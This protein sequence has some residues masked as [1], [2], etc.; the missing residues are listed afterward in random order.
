MPRIVCSDAARQSAAALKLMND[1]VP[2]HLDWS[3]LGAFEVLKAPLWVLDVERGRVLWANA[4]ALGLWRASSLADMQSTFEADRSEAAQARLNAT[5]EMVRAGQTLD[6]FW[7]VYP[8]GNPITFEA[9]FSGVILADRRLSVLVQGRPAGEREFPGELKRRVESYRHAPSPISLHRP[10]GTAFMRNPAAIRVF[11]PLDEDAARDDLAFQLGGAEV[12]AQA[13]ATLEHQPVQRQRVKVESRIGLRW[14]DVELRNVPDP[15]TGHESTLFSAQDVTE[16]QLAG[17]RLAAEKH[18]LEMI[19]T[20]K[21]LTEVLDALTREVE[22][23]SPDMKCSVL[24]LDEDGVHM[25]QASAPSLPEAYCKAIDGL[26]IG[27]RV[28]SC[29]TAMFR[30]QTVIV[31]DIADDPLWEDYRAIAA[32]HDLRACWSVP[33]LSSSGQVLG[34]FAAYYRLP[35]TPSGQEM[36]LLETG[37]HIAGV[38]VERDRA[39][40]ALRT[41]SEQLQM[42]MDAMP[43]SIAFADRNF[44]YAVVNRR[45]EE[46]FGRH[47]E[48]V[49]GKQTREVIGQDLFDQIKPYMDRVM[50]GEEVK[51]ERESIDAT[52]K[53]RHLEVHYLPL[54]GA[55][56]TVQGHFGIVHDITERKQSETLLHFLANH[57]QLTQLPNRNEFLRRLDEAVARAARYGH[58][59][60]VLFIDLDRFKNVNDTL[61]HECGD[62]LLVAVAHRF[63]ETLRG[64]DTVARLGGDE[65]TVILGEIGNPQE[66]A[67]SAQR[68]RATLAQPFVVQGQEVFASA[69]IGIS[70]Y[71][72]DGADAATLLRNADMAMYRAKEMGRNIFQFYSR[73]ATEAAMQRLGLESRLRRAVDRGEFVLHY[74]PIV[75]VESNRIVGLE[76]L[77]RWNRPD[78]GL[79]SPATFIPIAEETGL[80]VP[81]GDW[82]LDTACRQLRALHESGHA[83]LRIA[84]NL[85]PK[86]FRRRDMARTITDTLARTGLA[87]QH[88]ELEITE[89]SVMEN[90]EAAVRTLHA[91]K[92]MGVHLSIDDFGTGYSSLSQLKRFP[93]HALKVDQSFIRD[94][95]ADEDNAAI[96]SAIIAMG[97]R[98]RLTLVAEGVETHEQLAFLRERGCRYVQGYL[99]SRP[100]PADELAALLKR[101]LPTL[102][103]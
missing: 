24:L 76:S 95:P 15:L 37:R 2:L 28:G 58:R 40:Q 79:V 89:S 19:S 85:S 22:G 57:D 41:R 56:T 23:L 44:R 39:V 51:Y 9:S 98:L 43:F 101:G 3:S 11:G 100:I 7:T 96:A 18:L 33:I 61:G 83:G 48:Q 50:Q 46:L 36:E 91:L 38:A 27:E 32:A 31:T 10:D 88:L 86:Q 78:T 82:V 67:A 34:S 75:D 81:I 60:G 64:S 12:A 94:I 45:F 80:I 70:I 29:G 62:A 65:F 25:R 54:I 49:I 4:A 20:G 26:P 8:N 35:R 84:V 14:F 74:Q 97:Q 16:A 99:F 63:S 92:Q 30:G 42:V 73:E 69:S 72:D 68:L 77:V 71:P 47:R 53:T 87:A 17:Q 66:A 93:I 1:T 6:D 52:G 59:V 102:P 21:P 13:R 55:D 103:A 90:P 5:V